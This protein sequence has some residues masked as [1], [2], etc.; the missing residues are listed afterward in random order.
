MLCLASPY[1]AAE[2]DSFREDCAVGN[3][4]WERVKEEYAEWLV[5]MAN[6]WRATA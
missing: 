6:A 4:E 1:S 3:E 5:E 2:L